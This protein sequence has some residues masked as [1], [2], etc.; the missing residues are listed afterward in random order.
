M[1]VPRAGNSVQWALEPSHEKGGPRLWCFLCLSLLSPILCA[2]CQ[3]PSAMPALHAYL[4]R[5]LSVGSRLLTDS[6]DRVNQ[7]VAAH[8]FETS[9]DPA[10]SSAVRQGPTV[11]SQGPAHLW[12]KN[13]KGLRAV[14]AWGLSIEGRSVSPFF[15]EET[16]VTELLSMP[17]LSKMSSKSR[18]QKP[19]LLAP[20]LVFCHTLQSGFPMALPRWGFPHQ[21]FLYP[22]SVLPASQPLPANREHACLACS[23]SH[24]LE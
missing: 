14:P 8:Q 6:W 7:M 15:K 4:C 12:M 5:E 21:I 18:A 19:G 24:T 11:R 10:Y 17:E 9:P 3:S 16:E 2:L 20:D 1:Q 13:L 23:L 22:I